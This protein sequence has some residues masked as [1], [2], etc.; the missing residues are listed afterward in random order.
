MSSAHLLAVCKVPGCGVER[1]GACRLAEVEALLAAARADAAAARAEAAAAKAEIF[2][3]HDLVMRYKPRTDIIL[4]CCDAGWSEVGRACAFLCR[5][6]YRCMPAEALSAEACAR[7]RSGHALW[8]V[9]IDAPVS[10]SRS[11]CFR[12]PGARKPP[13]DESSSSSRWR[14]D[15]VDNPLLHRLFFSWGYTYAEYSAKR[16][17]HLKCI[18]DARQKLLLRKKSDASSAV[19]QWLEEP[20]TLRSWRLATAHLFDDDRCGVLNHELWNFLDLLED[21]RDC[22]HPLKLW[23][24]RA[25]EREHRDST[26]VIGTRLQVYARQGVLWRVRDLCSWQASVH[27][28]DV[29]GR[30]ALHFA[31]YAGH[32]GIVRDLLARGAAADAACE[33]GETPLHIACRH[34]F[35]GVARALVGALTRLRSSSGGA[36][37]G[38]AQGA[39]DAQDGDGVTAVFLASEHGHAR[40]VHLLASAGA[41]VTNTTIAER[42]FL[43]ADF[44]KRVDEMLL[45]EEWM[46][47]ASVDLVLLSGTDMHFAVT[48]LHAACIGG[49]T[50]A[51]RALLRAGANAEARDAHGA[52]CLHAAC[53][54]GQLAVVAKLL[55]RGA[56]MA[57]VD[58]DDKSC[59]EAAANAGCFDVVRELV[60]RGADVEDRRGGQTLFQ[61][62]ARLWEGAPS[63]A[64]RRAYEARMRGLLAC[65]ACIDAEEFGHGPGRT[66]LD[67]AA[68][69]GLLGLVTLLIELGANL[70]VDGLLCMPILFAIAH[71]HEFIVRTLLDAGADPATAAH[72]LRTVLGLVPGFRSGVGAAVCRLLL[73]APEH[74]EGADAPPLPAAAGAAAPPPLAEG[75][76]ALPP[77]PPPQ[78]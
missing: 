70:H 74:A 5:D 69:D 46:R 6:T 66:A 25:L 47:N 72:M 9:V 26:V 3:L 24:L 36:G 76:A 35:F 52:T 75:G 18:E 71:G 22:L 2:A 39:L 15:T 50:A 60:A 19:R 1:C 4:L 78:A 14:Q 54:A 48:A 55:D 73:G 13:C 29:R 58:F 20:P 32:A 38:A 12:L 51:V 67:K 8:R 16:Y 68:C 34:G 44:A 64:S 10:L 37:G 21:R 57:A 42:R 61:R 65:G 56:D 17:Y 49:H 43:G 11:E 28:R 63:A 23:Q 40:L 62:F 41:S 45:N 33:R 31:S 77:P 53:A 30:T 7:V 59:L 27:A